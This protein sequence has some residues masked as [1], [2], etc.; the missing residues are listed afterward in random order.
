MLLFESGEFSTGTFGEFST[1]IDIWNDFDLIHE[2]YDEVRKYY[3]GPLSLA[4]D[5]MVFNITKEKIIVRELVGPTNTYEEAVDPEAY[6][7]AKR[8]KN[9]PPSDWL[10]KGRLFPD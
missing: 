6:G 7:N 9:I 3:K 1:G 10:L 8:G 5:G 2:V 4:A